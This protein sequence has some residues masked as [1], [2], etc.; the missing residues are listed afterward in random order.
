MAAVSRRDPPAT[1]L[2]CRLCLPPRG[3]CS[4]FCA[5]SPLLV[6]TRPEKGTRASREWSRA[7]RSRL[8]ASARSGMSAG[9]A[10]HGIATARR[11]AQCRPDACLPLRTGREDPDPDGASVVQELLGRRMADSPTKI[12]PYRNGPYLVRGPFVIVDQ[13]GNEIEIKRRVVALCRCGRSQIRPFCDGTHKAIGFR[14]DSG[15]AV[16]TEDPR[17]TV[18][19]STQRGGRVPERA[20]RVEDSAS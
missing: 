14:A 20:A 6:P 3:L 1:A 5:I 11:G 12:T 2:P 19:Q 9:I 4:D 8:R 16:S 17:V 15:L 18:A 7:A 13:S 10:R